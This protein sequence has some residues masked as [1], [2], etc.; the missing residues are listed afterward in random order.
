[1]KGSGVGCSFEKGRSVDRVGG[2]LKGGIYFWLG[3]SDIARNAG[4][5]AAAGGRGRAF[6]LMPFF[7]CLLLG[8]R[9]RDVRWLWRGGS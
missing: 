9:V 6:T 3:V 4:T 7:F 5:R 8:S 2:G 1:M